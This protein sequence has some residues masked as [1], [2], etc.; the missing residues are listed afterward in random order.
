MQQFSLVDLFGDL[1]L[2][3]LQASKNTGYALL[4]W[5]LGGKNLPRPAPR[6]ILSMLLALFN[7]LFQKSALV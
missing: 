3:V 4:N 2:G 5:A 1:A 6:T 7:A